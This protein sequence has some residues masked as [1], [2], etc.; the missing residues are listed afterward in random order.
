MIT[1]KVL[2]ISGNTREL[3]RNEVVLEFLNEQAGTGTGELASKYIY[4]V[5]KTIDGT[6]I[7]IRRPA[8]LNKGF[9]FT[10]HI[11]NHDFGTKRKTDLPSHPYI[12]KDLKIKKLS[13]PE[14]YTKAILI[15]DRIYNCV[16]VTNEELRCISFDV[17]LPFETIAKAIKWLFIEQDITYWNWSGRAMFHNS[18]NQ[19]T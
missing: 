18:I 14:E 11:P 3:I 2:K 12:L 15:L 16:D 8:V 19:I 7:E 6:T 5:E 13:N 4:E 9:D 10:I 17:G 1:K